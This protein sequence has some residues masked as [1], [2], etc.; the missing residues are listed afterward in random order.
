MDYAFGFFSPPVRTSAHSEEPAV[1]TVDIARYDS[2]APRGRR[3]LLASSLA[4]AA[5]LAG[6]LVNEARAQQAPK[7]PAGAAAPEEKKK[8]IYADEWSLKIP[9]GG[10]ELPVEELLRDIG[11][12]LKKVVA[13]DEALKG[14]KV[15]FYTEADLNFNMLKNILGMF[16]V[17]IVFEE[18]DG[19]EFL[20][21]FMQRNMAQLIV[22]VPTPFYLEGEKLPETEQIVTA[23][24]TVKYADAAGVQ[25]AI[26]G[27][28]TRD[29]RRI[30]NVFQ[31][32]RSDAILITDVKSAVEFYIKIATALDQPIQGFEYKIVQIQYALADE[33]A[34]LVNQLYRQLEASGGS[35]GA[36]GGA[37]GQPPAPRAPGAAGQGGGA[38]QSQVVP[39]ARTNK[40]VILALPTEIARIEK[41]I[42]EID[43][44]VDPPPRHF[45]VYKCV[46]AYAIDLADRLNSLFGGGA[47]NF[48]TS[49]TANRNR[50]TLGTGTSNRR[51]GTTG[52]GS[53][54]RTGTTMGRNN[55]GGT[56]NNNI[57]GNTAAPRTTGAVG[58]ATGPVVNPGENMVETRIVPDEQTNSLLIQA[59]PDD[60]REIL[61]IL[62]ELDKKRFRVFI[63]CQIW[64]VS[65]SD[66]LLFALETAITDDASTNTNPN[67]LRGQGLANFGLTV[68][69][70]AADNSS[71]SLV[72]NFGQ[73]AGVA[74]TL[75]QGGLIFALTKGGF[76][77]IPLILQALAGESNAN[78]L[79]TPFALT[80]DNEQ[81]TFEIGDSRPFSVATTTGAA[82]NLFNGFDRADATS[83]LSV[84]PR[85]SSGNN[86]TLQLDLR[87]ESF[88]ASSNPSAPPP[89]TSR[90][91]TGT[92]TIPNRQ[93]VIFGGLEQET[94]RESRTKLPILGDIPY[95]G[96][97]FGKTSQQKSR[98]RLYVFIRPI[99]FTDDDFAGERRAS[100]FIHDQIRSE[101]ELGADKTTPVLPD[102]ILDAEAPGLKAALYGVFGDGA[103]TAFPEAEETREMRRAAAGSR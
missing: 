93:Y 89:S 71:V 97:L 77:K 52:I 75:T 25:N 92:V 66:D 102:E 81:A 48:G 18:V 79:T 85:V 7:P 40:V 32:P 90:A 64:E 45:H 96:Y 54:S 16:G 46:N 95:L 103:S 6:P 22:P 62:K 82:G 57:T 91:Y 94:V 101:S 44:R 34:N 73:V 47:G 29:P 74:S 11:D 70:V 68:P 87:I 84:V 41:L 69:V 55:L 15:K 72:P 17:E 49:S 76:D 5:A 56:L 13:I 33:L 67:P 88:G 61:A 3:A 14:K 20:K 24:Y 83:T 10:I 50:S 30:G 2:S 36:P 99:I 53:Q 9:K 86:L 31:A 1:Q 43:V 37:P 98:T 35:G 58:G 42:R 38:A 59:A 60:Y 100:G 21:A 28:Q 65:T 19:N 80:N 39:D 26:R 63:E 4:L 51:T 12:R 8:S 27:M 23:V 78:L